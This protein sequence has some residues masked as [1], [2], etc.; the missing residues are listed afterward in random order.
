MFY[1]EDKDSTNGV[2]LNSSRNRLAGGER[3]PLSSGDR[4]L[5]EPY[6]I[7]IS[8]E[9][10]QP[11]PRGRAEPANVADPFAALVD[12][13]DDP[14]APPQS[15]QPMRGGS[16]ESAQPNR[17]SPSPS[18]FDAPDQVSRADLDPIELLNLRDDRPVRKGPAPPS[19]R[20]LEAG[21]LLDNHF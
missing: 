5:I 12:L 8:I 10:D 2:F 14:F 1:I 19:A 20:D 9:A 3:H 16:F 21:S 11:A 4:L 6:E 18:A 17:P 7:R 15:A 13:V